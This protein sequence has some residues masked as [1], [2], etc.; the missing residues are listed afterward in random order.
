MSSE[1][2]KEMDKKMEAS[3]HHLNG[4]L[5]TI[6]TGRASLSLFDSIKINYYGTSTPLKQVASLSTPDASTVIIQPWDVSQLQEIEKAI[7]SSGLGLSPSNDGKI[8][9]IGIPPLSEERRKELVRL[10][11]KMGEECRI[12]IRNHRRDTND[13]LKAEQKEGTL[14]EDMLHKEQGEVQKIT[15]QKI[16]KV[17]AMLHKKESEVLEI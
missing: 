8:V 3:L 2:K 5:S 14:S 11:K 7:M 12:A 16:A 1:F 13:A 9:R 17:D 6:R 4:E 10:V 15:D